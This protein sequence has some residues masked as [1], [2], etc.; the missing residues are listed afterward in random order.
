MCNNL[1]IKESVTKIGLH[2]LI[3]SIWCWSLQDQNLL[4][5]SLSTLCTLTANNRLGVNAMSQTSISASTSNANSFNSSSNSLSSQSSYFSLSLLSTIIKSL[6]KSFINQQLKSSFIIQRYAF[7]ILTNC[8]QSNECKNL[9]WKSNLIQDFTQIDFQLI[10]LNSVKFNFKLEKLWLYFLVSLSFSQDGQQ[11]FIKVD[12]NLLA[13]VIK[14]LDPLLFCQQND[15]QQ[16]QIFLIQYLA[17]LILRNLSFNQANKSK[18]VSNGKL[19]NNYC[20]QLF[21]LILL[22]INIINFLNERIKNYLKLIN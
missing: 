15:F 17:L 5:T 4:K 18:L 7:S 14:F 9:I 13:V 6:Q 22:I 1:E 19:R 16:Q 12:T 8:A 20:F 11:F 3:H 2:S 21:K 10:K